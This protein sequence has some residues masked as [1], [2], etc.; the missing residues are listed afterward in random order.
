MIISDLTYVEN[1]SE[2]TSVQ[3]GCWSCEPE[4]TYFQNDFVG[5]NFLTSNAFQTSVNS[6]MT[7]SNSASAGAKGEA[8]NNWGLPSYSFTKADTISVTELL[9]SSFSGS[10]SAAVINFAF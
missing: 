2:S 4:Y 3:G 6:P 10:T 9:G 8:I 1:I 7:G 5:I